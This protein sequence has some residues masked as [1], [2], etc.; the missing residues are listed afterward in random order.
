MTLVEIFYIVKSL[1]QLHFSFRVICFCLQ[2]FHRI[3]LFFLLPHFP[4]QFLCLL[5]IFDGL[6]VSS[7]SIFNNIIMVFRISFKADLIITVST[8][9]VK[10]KHFNPQISLLVTYL[11]PHIKLSTNVQVVGTNITS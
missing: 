4:H 9:Q 7:P 3:S 5:G 2:K 8:F 6:I 11:H 1:H 10:S